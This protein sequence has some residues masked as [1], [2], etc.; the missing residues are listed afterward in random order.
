LNLDWMRRASDEEFERGI[1]E[2]PLT[3]LVDFQWEMLNEFREF[4]EGS[5]TF[6]D[7]RGLP[8]P[9][10]EYF[11]IGHRLNVV[12]RLILDKRDDPQTAPIIHEHRREIDK[13]ERETRASVVAYR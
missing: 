1:A 2:A 6:R 4:K 12:M 13:L 11:L 3:A 7:D 8:N 10:E 9:S 5:R